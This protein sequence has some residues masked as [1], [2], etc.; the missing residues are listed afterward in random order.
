MHRV[1]EGR[2]A[3]A[4]EAVGDAV[5]RIW[6]GKKLWVVKVANEVTL[7]RME[8]AIGFLKT[9]GEKDDTTG[10]VDVLFG[11]RAAKEVAH[12]YEK[13]EVDWFDKGL[14]DSQKE[15]V[16]FALASEEVGGSL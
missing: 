10:L 5:D 6:S 7:K 8:K 12:E 1:F 14:N 15:A 4:V 2:L 3:L 9:L 16:R 11:R 13:M